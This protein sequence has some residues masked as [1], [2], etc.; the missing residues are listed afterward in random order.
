MNDKSEIMHRCVQ[1]II[2]CGVTE[3]LAV[4]PLCRLLWK[5]GFS[6][7]PQ[8]YVDTKLSALI[9]GLAYALIWGLGMRVMDGGKTDIALVFASLLFGSLMALLHQWQLR[10]LRKK[11]NL[12]DWSVILQRAEAGIHAEQ[13]ALSDRL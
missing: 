12:P 8:L 5:Y 4:S 1:E 3:K 9:W 6:A 10:G 2:R 7:R 11:M 13:E